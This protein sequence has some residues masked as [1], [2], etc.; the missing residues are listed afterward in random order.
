MTPWGMP[1]KK[2]EE[3][4]DYGDYLEYVYQWEQDMRLMEEEGDI[5][6]DDMLE[7]QILMG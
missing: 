1:P 6:Y 3:F 4:A 5:M 7:L 2:A